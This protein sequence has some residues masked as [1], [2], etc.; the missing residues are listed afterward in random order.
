MQQRLDLP[1]MNVAARRLV[2]DRSHQL[3]VL[4]AH[5]PSLRVLL[6]YI[7]I[8]NPMLGAGLSGT[9][10]VDTPRPGDASREPLY[11]TPG[12][13]LGD[14]FAPQ[15]LALALLA[16]KLVTVA[17]PEDPFVCG[18]QHLH[19]TAREAVSAQN[20]HLRGRVARPANSQCHRGQ[21]N[22]ARLWIACGLV[23]HIVCR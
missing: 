15:G 11:G 17:A 4:V 18:L 14:M 2:E 10:P 22:A 16:A 7:S 19:G 3:F 23:V 8:R 13:G 9:L 5:A 21:H 12:R 20:G 6:D 1:P